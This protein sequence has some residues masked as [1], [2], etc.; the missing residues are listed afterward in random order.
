M[1]RFYAYQLF[2]WP[3]LRVLVDWKSWHYWKVKILCLTWELFPNIKIYIHTHKHKHTFYTH[4]FRIELLFASSISKLVFLIWHEFEVFFC[5][6][7]FFLISNTECSPSS[8]YFWKAHLPI[9][10]YISN[11][12]ICQGL[13]LGCMFNPVDQS[14]TVLI[15][16]A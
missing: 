12:L 5:F 8:L 9:N 13:S 6:L 16:V 1:P 11:F 4:F 15:N 3:G 2:L 10:L 7:F 14:Y